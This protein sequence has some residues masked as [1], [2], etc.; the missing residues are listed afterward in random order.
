[1]I[2]MPT[3]PTQSWVEK[4]WPAFVINFGILSGGV[5]F[6]IFG[7]SG[8]SL[9][10][11]ITLCS[12]IVGVKWPKVVFFV[13]AKWTELAKWYAKIFRVFIERIC[14]YL[15]LRAV[16]IGKQSPRLSLSAPSGSMWKPRYNQSSDSLIGKPSHNSPRKKGNGRVGEYVVWAWSSGNLWAVW[17]IPFFLLLA[18]LQRNEPNVKAENIYTLF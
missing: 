15:I 9:S 13:Y 5:L 12:Y 14:F 8:I 18:P 6:L 2:M 1:M 16:G 4:F 10:L 17:F 7:W 11:G 3:N